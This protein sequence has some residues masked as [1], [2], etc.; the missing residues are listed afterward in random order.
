MENPYL[1]TFTYNN[2]DYTVDSLG[3]LE[4]PSN[5]DENFAEGMALQLNIPDGLSEE[6]W[7]VIRFIR[8]KFEKTKVCPIIFTTCK[9]NNLKLK[10]LERLFPT[11]YQRGACKISGITYREGYITYY[12][13]D[14]I[15]RPKKAV[16][17]EKCYR[18]DSNG[19]LVDS[20]EWDEEFA[21]NKAFELKMPWLLTKQHWDIINYIR[22]NYT[23]KKDIPNVFETCEHFKLEI[24]E[25]EKLFPDG[26]HRGAI[27][28]AGLRL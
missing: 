8:E 9:N 13:W 28:I 24:D 4:D 15:N 27:K 20:T 10:D 14:N 7:K 11:G 19:F 25:F 22:Y 2:K 6:H 16:K 23:T 12:Y 21:L 17:K 18:V 3:F 5:W 26:Y 1:K